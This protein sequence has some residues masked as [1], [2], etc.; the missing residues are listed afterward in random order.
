MLDLSAFSVQL[1][2]DP[3]LVQLSISY[4]AGPSEWSAICAVG[5]ACPTALA[6]AITVLFDNS[7][8]TAKA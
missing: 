5:T 6:M 8:A 7:F 3:G 4:H 1:E 2:W